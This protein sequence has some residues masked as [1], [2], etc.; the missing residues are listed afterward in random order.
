MSDFKYGKSL[1]RGLTWYCQVPG[2][3]WATAPHIGWQLARA[4]DG[5]WVLMRPGQAQLN[6]NA[7][8]LSDAMEAAFDEWVKK[9]EAS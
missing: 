8:K 7:R 9:V 1:T 5:T 2:G 6:T 4:S 3:L